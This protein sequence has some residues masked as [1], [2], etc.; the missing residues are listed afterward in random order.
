M[1]KFAKGGLVN[2]ERKNSPNVN[3]CGSFLVSRSQYEKYG[4]GFLRKI[5]GNP[6]AEL[7]VVD[8]DRL[9]K[10]TLGEKMLLLK[11]A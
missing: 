9:E 6:C 7:I 11:S 10:M 3:H 1:R 4:A 5:N 2:P 8:D